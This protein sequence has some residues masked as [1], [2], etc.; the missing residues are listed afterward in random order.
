MHEMNKYHTHL[1]NKNALNKNTLINVFF[2]KQN[3]AI[4]YYW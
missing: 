1:P 4:L 2:V 3:Y